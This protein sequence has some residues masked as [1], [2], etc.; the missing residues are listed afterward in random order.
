MRASKSLAGVRRRT[1][2]VVAGVL[3]LTAVSV[4]CFDLATAAPAQRDSGGQLWA[5]P[6]APPGQLDCRGVAAAQS[7]DGRALYVAATAAA[8][9]GSPRDIVLLKY[10][11]DGTLL[12][13]QV[14]GGAG[15]DRPAAIAVDADG[16]V[17]LAGTT[18]SDATGDDVLV[19]EYSSLGARRW[20]AHY[21][22]PGR[23]ADVATDVDVTMVPHRSTVYVAATT[24][25][26]GGSRA[27]IIKYDSTGRR[28]WVRRYSPAAGQSSAT[29]ITLDLRGNA[30]V[31]GR[32]TSHGDL[33]GL[34]V[35]YAGNGARLWT[36]TATGARQRDSGILDVAIG[37]G[38]TAHVYVCG[39]RGVSLGAVAML[40]SYTATG[41]RHEWTAMLGAAG[42]GE[43]TFRSVAAD[44]NGSALVAGEIAGAGKTGPQAVVAK[45]GVRSG[46]TLWVHLFNA[47][48]TSDDDTLSAVAV[49]GFD[50]AFAVGT[51]HTREGDRMSALSY[52]DAG[53]LRWTK[54]YGGPAGAPGGGNALT[55]NVA[56]GAP[57]A[58]GYAADGAGAI[59]ATVV[60]YQR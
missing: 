51:S 49:N 50:E 4:A 14:I 1:A 52:T 21:R 53:V 60:A 5:S 45:Y 57:Y 9:A 2:A 38:T 17:V 40:A 12:W 27:T 55:L 58:V 30:Y 25:G 24:S 19:A 22:G 15:D 11:D 16:N 8:A 36:A 29:A 18:Q 59:K 41:G 39:S 28:A 31:G 43:S 33:Q 56:T 32:F 10:A 34:L 37:Q 23:G 20:A 47:T 7:H 3:V 42:L 26:A 48:A 35:K 13:Q 46:A 6:Y 54:L 44:R